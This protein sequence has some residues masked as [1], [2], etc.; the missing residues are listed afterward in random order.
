MKTIK[1]NKGKSEGPK[2]CFLDIESTS[3]EAD[4]GIVIGI[5]LMDESGRSR[6]L[7]AKTPKEEARMLN[8]FLSIL[9]DYHMMITWRGK[10]FDVPFLI[11][12]LIKNKIEVEKLIN[13]YHL[14]LAEFLKANLRLSRSD[15]YHVCR[16]L[17]IKKDMELSGL[18]MPR[19]YLNSMKGDLKARKMIK[20]HCID[21]LRSLRQVYVKVKPLLRAMKPELAI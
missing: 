10:D 7:F 19:L 6:F 12:R 9:K 18:D 17:G 2:V 11:A 21:D 5:G 15:L 8:S 4:T 16:F 1:G 14:D 20:R 3:L 13:I